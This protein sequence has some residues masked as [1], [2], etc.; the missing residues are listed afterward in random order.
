[1]TH[2]YILQSKRPQVPQTS[3]A[4]RYA[5]TFPDVQIKARRVAFTVFLHRVR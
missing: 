4:L 2:T 1:M 5:R 3:V